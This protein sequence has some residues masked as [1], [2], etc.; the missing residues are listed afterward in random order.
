MAAEITPPELS[1]A[2]RLLAGKA[3]KMFGGAGDELSTDAALF[4]LEPA[5]LAQLLCVRCLDCVDGAT[6]EAEISASAV[7]ISSE[8]SVNG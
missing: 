4:G 8:I 1:A 2:T 6:A 5:Q 7:E 3:V